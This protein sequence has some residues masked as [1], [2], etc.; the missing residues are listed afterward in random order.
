MKNKLDEIAEEYAEIFEGMDWE[1][2]APSFKGV[3][4]KDEI[5]KDIIDKAMRLKKC[6]SDDYIA[7]GR[8]I[9]VKKLLEDEDG[10]YFW[11]Y[12]ISLGNEFIDENELDEILESSMETKG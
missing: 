1:W 5:K 7:S 10:I 2:D 4:G 9:V 3:P 12:I 6:S 11:E 8:I